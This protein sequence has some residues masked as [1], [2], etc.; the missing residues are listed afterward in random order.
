MTSL[1]YRIVYPDSPGYPKN[2]TQ[3]DG[4]PKK[5]YIAGDIIDADKKAVAIIGSRRM[6]D[7]GKKMAWEF[8]LYLAEKG[9]TIV[10]GMARGVDTIA[11]KA[12]LF[13][14][15]R[16]IAVLGSGIDVIY[17]PEN[18]FLANTISKHGAVV[19]E[20]ELGTP[21]YAKNFLSRNRIISGLSIATLVVEGS[22]RSGTLSISNWAANQ[23]R[24]VF[25]IP[26]RVDSPL[27]ALPNYLIE[28]GAI[29]V[30][31]P[32]DVLDM[33]G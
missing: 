30:T 7:Y 19:T 32:E 29:P 5:L 26:G 6:S 33:L 10:S 23:G 24:D 18:S 11:H 12:A 2:L 25:A 27:S 4:H 22:A 20:F 13:A 3:I 28:N 14:N 15:G 31:K 17:P 21:P 1:V 16:T 9:V 8:S